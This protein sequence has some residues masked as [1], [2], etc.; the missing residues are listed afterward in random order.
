M[1]ICTENCIHDSMLSMG[2][3]FDEKMLKVELMCVR[4]WSTLQCVTTRWSVPGLGL[5]NCP[6]SGACTMTLIRIE[7]V[8]KLTSQQLVWDVFISSVTM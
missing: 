5:G 6:V 3:I 1:C 8:L 4:T 7:H 2:K